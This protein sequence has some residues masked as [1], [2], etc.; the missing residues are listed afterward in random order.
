MDFPVSL[1][2]NLITKRNTINVSVK[3]LDH[4]FSYAIAYLTRTAFRCFV[5][6]Q[7]LN[8]YLAFADGASAGP[9]RGESKYGLR[10]TSGIYYIQNR[11]SDCYVVKFSDVLSHG[12]N[13]MDAVEWSGRGLF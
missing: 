11:N 6:R 12:I 10:L 2:L 1:K 5:L 3:N 9:R 13:E 7:L 8:C 4:R